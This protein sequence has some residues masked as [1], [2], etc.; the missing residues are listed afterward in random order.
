MQSILITIIVTKLLTAIYAT[1]YATV[2]YATMRWYATMH[3]M[4]LCDMPLCMICHYVICHYVIRHYLWYAT[5]CDTATMWYAT[6]ICHYVICH[7][8][9]YATMHDLP[10]CDMPLCMICHCV[11]YATVVICHY[12]SYAP[13]CDMPLYAWN[14]TVICHYPW[15]AIMHDMPLCMICHY[16]WY[17]TMHDVALLVWYQYLIKL[18][19]RSWNICHGTNMETNNEPGH[20]LVIFFEREAHNY[21]KNYLKWLNVIV[22][23][24]YPQI[25]R[26]PI[27]FISNLNNIYFPNGSIIYLP[28]NINY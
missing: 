15:Y 27:C 25:F 18:C 2:W 17:A 26:F 1:G 14:A 19:K 5:M 12:A 7:Y 28:M 20:L 22:N 24:Y 16:A 9:W 23:H 6:M 3:D 10:L 11:G 8:A 4:P 21:I 13:L